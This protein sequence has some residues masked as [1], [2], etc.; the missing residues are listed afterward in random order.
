MWILISWLVKANPP[1][2]GSISSPKNNPTNLKSVLGR[3]YVKGIC[4][5]MCVPW[6]IDFLL[7][8]SNGFLSVFLVVCCQIPSKTSLAH[9]A[10]NNHH[11]LDLLVRC[12]V[13]ISNKSFPKL[14]CFDGDLNAS[15]HKKSPE[16]QKKSQMKGFSLSRPGP[17]KEGLNFLFPT[18][19][20]ISKS[21][22]G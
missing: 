7:F 20:G 1:K 11:Y 4:M 14:W 15:I 19:Y 17:S 3:E 18:T 22:K 12:L 6:W 10:G 2:L 13:N 21:S 16:K 5:N 9:R 8:T